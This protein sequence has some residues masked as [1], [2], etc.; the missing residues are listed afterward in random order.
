MT[1]ITPQFDATAC[2]DAQASDPRTLGWMAGWPPIADKRITYQG[3]RF[4]KFPEVR[5]TLSHMRE[6]VPTASVRRGPGPRTAF[7]T[8]PDGDSAAIESLT[9]TDLDGRQRNFEDAVQETYTDGIIVLH[10]GRVVYERYLGALRPELPHSCFSITKSIAGAIAASLIS[11]GVLDE[12]K[13]IP[14]YIPELRGSAWEDATLRQVIEMETGLDYGEDYSDERSGIWDY[15][16]AAGMRPRSSDYNGPDGLYDYLTTIRKKGEHGVGYAYSTLNTE[17]MAWVMARV[18]GRTFGQML[19]ESLW[20]PL[21]C[22]EDGYLLIDS[23]G[24]PLAGIGLHA[25]L[26]DLAR[27]GELMRREG[28]WNGRQLIPAAVVHEIQR[29]GDPAK[30]AVTGHRAA[31]GWSSRN[32]W[33]TAHDELE[34]F[35]A[36]GIHGQRLYIAP[37]A[38]MV[39]VRFAS[40][41]FVTYNGIDPVTRPMLS[42]LGNMLRG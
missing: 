37:K 42:A 9:F 5:W 12:T 34:A 16:R 21:G 24:M 35:M 17:V 31:V 2:A 26:R 13:L 25:T 10:R 32:M 6:L 1:A 41:P 33:Y 39:V 28:D 14:H 20:G 36:G 23:A 11:D 30:L 18:A 29:G 4:L 8:P 19:E 22:D 15:A 38:E 40:H 27:F 7:D 3:D